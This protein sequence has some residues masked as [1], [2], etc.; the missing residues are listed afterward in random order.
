MTENK[1]TTALLNHKAVG[2]SG[3]VGTEVLVLCKCETAFT[4]RA[5]KASK[6]FSET[7]SLNILTGSEEM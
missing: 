2:S 3:N 5:I 6:S 1:A 4:L 7:L